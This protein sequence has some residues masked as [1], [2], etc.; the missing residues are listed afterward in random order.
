VIITAP[1]SSANLG[2]GFDSLAIALGLPFRL[3][4]GESGDGDDFLPVEASH[5]AAVAFRAAGGDPAV[6]LF[7]RSPVPPGRGLGFSGAARVAGAY[8]AG[9][10]DGLDHAAARDG[11]LAVAAGLEGHPENAAASAAGGFVVAAAG[12]VLGLPVPD[13]LSIIVWSPDTTTSTDASRRSLPVRVGLDDATFSVGRAALWVAAL[14]TGD[15]DA[16]RDACED[17]LHQDHRLA[18]RPG[19]RAARDHLLGRPEVLAAWLSGSGPSIAALVPSGPADVVAADLPA[20]AQVRVLTVD[21]VGVHL[22]DES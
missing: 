13:G 15:L 20:G 4:V 2:P 3:A 16:L 18:A 14:A 8:A 7:W 10:T 1:A 12:R 19:S 6:E 22:E 11:A 5:P 17:R 21:P 9:R